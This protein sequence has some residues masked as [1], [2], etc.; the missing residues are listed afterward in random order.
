VWIVCG[1]NKVIKRVLETKQAIAELK[2]LSKLKSNK[3]EGVINLEDY[4]VDSLNFV[5]LVF[6][7]LQPVNIENFTL[8][9]LCKHF[10]G[11]L[12]V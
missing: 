12:Q 8:E 9:I 11:L 10:S 5:C 7:V 3:V 4:F 1:K 6:P 2:I